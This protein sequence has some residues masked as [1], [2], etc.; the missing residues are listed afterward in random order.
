MRPS[1]WAP[2]LCIWPLMRP[3]DCPKKSWACCRYCSSCDCCWPP[4][5][6]FGPSLTGLSFSK[7][8]KSRSSATVV[9]RGGPLCAPPRNGRAGACRPRPLRALRL[10][11]SRSFALPFFSFALPLRWSERPSD[12]LLWSPVTAPAASFIRPLALSAIPSLRSSLLL[13][14]ATFPSFRLFAYGSPC[15]SLPL[16]FYRLQSRGV[17]GATISAVGRRRTLAPS[18]GLPPPSRLRSYPA[19]VT[20]LPYPHA[21]ER[22][23]NLRRDPIFSPR[24][25]SG[26]PSVSPLDG[27][28]AETVTPARPGFRRRRR[29]PRRRPSPPRRPCSRPRPWFGRRAWSRRSRGGA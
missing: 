28:E 4:C 9:L 27:G 8:S 21:P 23:A 15:G 26:L 20:R 5:C 12:F 11:L 25:H 3:I 7:F 22:N 19:S 13:F 29:C 2:S 24:D 17:G 6:W 1:S 18:R 16:S 10:Y 14:P